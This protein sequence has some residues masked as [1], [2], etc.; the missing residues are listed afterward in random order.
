MYFIKVRY[1]RRRGDLHNKMQK[2][3]HDMMNVR[4][5]L[6]STPEMD[7]MPEGD[8]YETE[9]DVF[10]VLNAAG[11]KKEDIE[12]TFHDIY[13]RIRGRRL[14]M[15]PAGLPVKYHQ[16]EIG[17]GDFERIF[18]IPE[19]VDKDHI[20]ASYEDGLLTVRMKKRKKPRSVSVKIRS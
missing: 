12:V 5:P 6:F 17:H 1:D 2:M 20:E 16:I 9:G 18:R 3:M 10:L 11:V 13:L 8:I 7:W 15:L 14:R 4:R 19:Q